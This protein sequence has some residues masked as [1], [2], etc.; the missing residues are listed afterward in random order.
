MDRLGESE[1]S[2][3]TILGESSSSM[4]S[5]DYGEF[6]ISLRSYQSS[7]PGVD[8]TFGY[9]PIEAIRL[10]NERMREL[11]ESLGEQKINFEQSGERWYVSPLGDDFTVDVC[12][13]DD[14][15]AVVV[16]TIVHRWRSSPSTDSQDNGTCS[17]PGDGHSYSL[18]TKMMKHN[19][20][21][22]GKSSDAR[23]YRAREGSFVFLSSMS[24]CVLFGDGKLQKALHDFILTAISI[25]WDFK[26][27]S[28]KRDCGKAWRLKTRRK[29]RRTASDRYVSQA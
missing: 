19:A 2:M 7:T 17:N 18:M 8:R 29:S 6:D 28:L 4:M 23:I 13:A 1:G 3:L 21:L 24:L 10:L 22:K 9:T 16:S 12:I 14:A 25:K 11:G 26:K 5:D 20:L 15:K 27:V